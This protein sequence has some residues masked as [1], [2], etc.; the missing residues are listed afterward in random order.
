MN[1]IINDN[2]SLIQSIESQFS[3]K[4]LKIS[5]SCIKINIQNAEN[6]INSSYH[7]LS[8][9]YEYLEKIKEQLDGL[10]KGTIDYLILSS[11]IDV[12]GV[13]V[14]EIDY[15]VSQSIYDKKYLI[16]PSTYLEKTI[17]FPFGFSY[18]FTDSPVG[19]P[20]SSAKNKPYFIYDC[21]I[22]DSSILKLDLFFKP[23]EIKKVICTVTNTQL[24]NINTLVN[25]NGSIGLFINSHSDTEWEFDIF[26]N[27]D[28]L[29]DNTNIINFNTNSIYGTLLSINCSE[30]IIKLSDYPNLIIII[31]YLQNITDTALKTV[32]NYIDIM[33]IYLYIC[34]INSKLNNTQQYL[35]T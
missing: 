5:N 4:L 28:N 16:I 2:S 8:I 7:Y 20:I 6:T 9:I 10:S 18:N 3:T 30:P 14:K 32:W 31:H 12:I 19:L 1:I 27:Y 34:T 17:K 22:I 25:I 15:T 29:I 35:L 13:Y 24:P 21:P 23:L 11:L 33:N 26:Y